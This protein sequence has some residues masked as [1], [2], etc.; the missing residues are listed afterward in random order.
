MIEE[1]DSDPGNRLLEENYNGSWSVSLLGSCYKMTWW[2]IIASKSR[3]Y[4][5]TTR[6]NL[7]GS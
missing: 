4:R 7:C 6:D 2:D 5:N 3:L 1:E